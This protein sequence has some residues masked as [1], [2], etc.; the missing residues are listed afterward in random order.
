MDGEREVQAAVDEGRLRK[1]KQFR[2]TR[3]SQCLKTLSV[4]QNKSQLF[5]NKSQIFQKM[6]QLF[7]KLSQLSQKKSQLFQ[8]KS[9]HSQKISQFSMKN[10]TEF[11]FFLNLK[12]LPSVI[13]FRR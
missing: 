3:I 12:Q 13:F 8:K 5:Q 6:S 10:F 9:Q 2:L 1:G 4:F 11:S 7:Q